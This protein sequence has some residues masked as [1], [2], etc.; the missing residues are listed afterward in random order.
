MT[1][2][3]HRHPLVLPIELHQKLKALAD[4]DR[5][6]LNSYL[7]LQLEKLVAEEKRNG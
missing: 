2:D 4:I 6:P 5:R 3:T 1:K 7:V